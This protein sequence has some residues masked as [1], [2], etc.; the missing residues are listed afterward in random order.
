MCG[1]TGGASGKSHGNDTFTRCR[2]SPVCN[3][4]HLELAGAL[5]ERGQFNR[6]V[7]EMVKLELVGQPRVSLN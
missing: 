6:L 1:G 5:L 3:E 2:T 4:A 7:V